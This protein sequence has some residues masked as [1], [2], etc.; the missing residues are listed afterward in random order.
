RRP[1][2]SLSQMPC[3]SV[4]SMCGER[5]DSLRSRMPLHTL[6]KH[7]PRTEESDPAPILYSLLHTRHH[8]LLQSPNNK[9]YYNIACYPDDLI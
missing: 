4:L 9:S 3:R 1:L 5:Y 2:P 7:T 8:A 6:I